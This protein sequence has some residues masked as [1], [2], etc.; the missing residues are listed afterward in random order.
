MNVDAP[1]QNSVK[2]NIE[3]GAISVNVFDNCQD[4]ILQLME[5]NTY[6]KFLASTYCNDFLKQKLESSTHFLGFELEQ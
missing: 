6:T 2:T 5:L 1:M 4:E 3:A